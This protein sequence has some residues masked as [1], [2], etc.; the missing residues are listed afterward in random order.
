MGEVLSPVGGE[1]L[2]GKPAEL[3]AMG[4]G[5]SRIVVFSFSKA[6]S[7]DSKQWNERV[8]KDLGADSPA[9]VITAI[10][11]EAVPRLFRG[12]AISGIKSDMPRALWDKTILVYKDEA[13]WKKR[14]AVSSDKHAYV[15]LLDGEG[16]ARWMSSGAFTEAEYARLR[17]QILE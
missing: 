7:A 3:P 6:A 13:A 16:R 14:L 9:I 4:A 15:L 12:M 10:V 17:K 5:S 2:S 11:L 8:A 1:T